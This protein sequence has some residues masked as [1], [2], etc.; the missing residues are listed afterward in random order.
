VPDDQGPTAVGESVEHAPERRTQRCRVR[1]DELGIRI[2]H[3]FERAAPRL[4]VRLAPTFF[5]LRAQ[6]GLDHDSA[7][8][9]LAQRSEKA[10]QRLGRT[11][12]ARRNKQVVA[13]VQA[14]TD[15]RRRAHTLLCQY[16]PI[17]VRVPSQL[18]VSRHFHTLIAADPR[19]KTPGVPLDDCQDDDN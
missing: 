7:R 12:R 9:T 14:R 1:F 11:L 15:L 3:R 16:I 19:R 8:N 10:R 17:S 4:L 2:A 6:T 13:A 5:S 18:D